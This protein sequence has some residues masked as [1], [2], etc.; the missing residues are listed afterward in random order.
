[1]ISG[2]TSNNPDLDLYLFDPNGNEV[3]SSEFTTRQEELGYSPTMTGT[4][5]LRVRSF[6]GS[7]PYFVD[8]SIGKTGYARPQSATPT[9]VRLVPA[10]PP[11]VTANGSPGGPAGPPPR[12]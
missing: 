7:A 12:A 4:Y 1:T 6:R 10:F 9:T 5:T 8:I 2:G 11:C 3:A